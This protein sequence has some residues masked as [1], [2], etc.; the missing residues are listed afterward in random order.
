MLK[1]KGKQ[2]KK[3]RASWFC[4]NELQNKTVKT[5]AL[6]KTKV[7]LGESQTMKEVTENT[8]NADKL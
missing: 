3:N 1:T 2:E 7:K 4:N 5:K 6:A 8:T